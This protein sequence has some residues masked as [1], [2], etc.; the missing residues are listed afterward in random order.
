MSPKLI[1]LEF[2]LKAVRALRVVPEIAVA[3]EALRREE[4]LQAEVERLRFA[5][6]PAELAATGTGGGK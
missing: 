5:E 4:E 6:Q 2:E 3:R 1:V